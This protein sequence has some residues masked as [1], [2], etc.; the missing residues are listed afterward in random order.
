MRMRR[1][2][3]EGSLTERQKETQR[4][5]KIERNRHKDKNIGIDPKRR[6][7]N[8]RRW[9]TERKRHN[10]KETQRKQIDKD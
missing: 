4:L 2:A 6:A 7:E 8:G 1:K 10:Y 9:E 5:N 3:D